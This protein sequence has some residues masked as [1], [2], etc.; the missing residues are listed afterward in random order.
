MRKGV[1][2]VR[3]LLIRILRVLPFAALWGWFVVAPALAGTPPGEA[4]A[5]ERSVEVPRI[6]VGGK[7]IPPDIV[8]AAVD[9]RLAQHRVIHSEPTPE[10]AKSLVE[11]A[12]RELVGRE[13]LC[14]AAEEKG[15]A[16]SR[17]EIDAYLANKAA[18]FGGGDAYKRFLEGNG[19]PWETYER[20]ASRALLASTYVDRELAPHVEVSPSEVE[21]TYRKRIE[22][23]IVSR[24][25]KMFDYINIDTADSESSKKKVEELLR[26]FATPSAPVERIQKV[27]AKVRDALS[28]AATSRIGWD[29]VAED[30]TGDPWWDYLSGVE[31][32]QARFARNPSRERS[33]YYF[34]VK[35]SVPGVTTS[36]SEVSG[37]IEKELRALKLGAAVEREV[38]RLRAV[39]PVEVR[40]AGS[41]SDRKP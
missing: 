33:L 32:G 6:F 2:P 8:S 9:L 22:E 30:L 38:E 5:P 17:E 4:K 39:H 25:T 16:A 19:I 13:L 23:F 18:M 26:G 20:I 29:M 21:E 7:E 40:F 41:S 24:G 35:K 15:L 31:E 10:R 36:L 28:G 1:E 14:R 3:G 37:R 11:A 27:H 34:H 12:A